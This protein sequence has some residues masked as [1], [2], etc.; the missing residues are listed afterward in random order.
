MDTAERWDLVLKVERMARWHANRYSK[1]ADFDDMYQEAMLALWE[2]TETYDP[3]LGRF[4][5]WGG[6]RVRKQLAR[7]LKAN[8]VTPDADPAHDNEVVLGEPEPEPYGEPEAID[9]ALRRLPEPDRELLLRIVGGKGQI[10]KVAGEK[11]MTRQQVEQRYRRALANLGAA[12]FG[13]DKAHGTRLGAFLWSIRD[14]EWHTLARVRY[15]I[16]AN[17]K[18]VASLASRALRDGLIETRAK[19]VR[20]K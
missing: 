20:L 15:A 8:A 18:T 11:G 10:V 17:D 16:V 7:K 19:M 6:Y 14:R 4:S 9:S 13:L 12:Y 5:T 3:A 1:S 2:A